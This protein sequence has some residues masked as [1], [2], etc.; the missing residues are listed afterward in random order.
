MRINLLRRREGSM[1]IEGLFTLPFV[2][3]LILLTRFLFE[4]AMTRHEVSVHTRG[5]AV[6]AA[7]S[8]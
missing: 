6:S 4:G 1:A 5:S 3:V 8:Y 7:A 2:A